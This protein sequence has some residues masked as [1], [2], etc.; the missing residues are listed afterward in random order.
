ML[1]DDGCESAYGVGLQFEGLW[2]VVLQDYPCA[3]FYLAVPSGYGEASF[4]S[5][6]L[7]VGQV[8]EGGVH[9]EFEGCSFL[10]HALYGHHSSAYSYLGCGYAYAFVLRVGHG[11][12]HALLEGFELGCG[13]VG[14]G[15]GCARL[16]QEGGVFGVIYGP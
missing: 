13:D 12:Q 14:A 6:A 1:E 10:V 4:A 7:L 5:G 2:V 11:E 3:A 16:A 15:K 8:D 9:V